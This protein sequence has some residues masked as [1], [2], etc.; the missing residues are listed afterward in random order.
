MDDRASEHRV[1]RDQAFRSTG[2]ALKLALFSG[3]APTEGRYGG[4][5]VVMTRGLL[6]RTHHVST[7]M[8]DIDEQSSRQTSSDISLGVRGLSAK[9]TPVIDAP[10]CLPGT[11]PLSGFL[12]LSAVSSHRRLVALFH[13]TSAHR[14][15][16]SRAFPAQ[17]AVV[18]LDT[19]CSPAVTSA[20]NTTS[21]EADVASVSR[22]TSKLLLRLSIRHPSMCF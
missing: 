14:L 10:D 6:R 4:P 5:S 16:A 1:H 15:G 13:A 9:S 2:T 7:D 11:I 12:T 8:T 3:T 19:R 17:S 22:S 21:T 18:P 20:R